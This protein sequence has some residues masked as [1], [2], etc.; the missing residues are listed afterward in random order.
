M[1]DAYE[2]DA[3]YQSYSSSHHL[4]K[5]PALHTQHP[6]HYSEGVAPGYDM[7]NYPARVQMWT[8]PSHRYA[9]THHS[10]GGG[11]G[12]RDGGRRREGSVTCEER[13]AYTR[14]RHTRILSL[15]VG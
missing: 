13:V 3:D 5:R 10:H 6:Y 11:H 9:H 2:V 1:E 15:N 4:Q 8:G 14:E 7:P 12:V